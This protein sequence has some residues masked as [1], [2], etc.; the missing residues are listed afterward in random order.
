MK[1]KIYISFMML[2]M[3]FAG[4][5]CKKNEGKGGKLS[6]KGKV[7]ANY[8]NKTFKSIRT[9]GYIAD[10]DVFIL[11]GDET[12]NGDD[13]KTSYDG[14]YEFKYLAKGKYKIY[15]Y[16][17][18]PLTQKK[19][20]VMKEVDLTDDITLEDLVVNVEDKSTGT[21]AIRGKIHVTEFDDT[22][23]FPTGNAYYIMDEDVFLIEEGDS[24]YSVKESTNHLGMYEFRGLRKGKYKLYVFSENSKA[25]IPGGQEAVV[26]DVEIID[27]DLNLTDFE[28]IKN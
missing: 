19:V 28:I 18:D 27:G 3:L 12:I 5:S 13:T 22:Y 20:S 8:Y 24:S 23:S 4:I 17:I 1:T 15:T 26:R 10:E 6:I 16:S 25:I 7:Y 9:Q 2:L 21:F 14:S 11:Y